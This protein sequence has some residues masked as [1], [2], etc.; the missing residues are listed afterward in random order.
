[1]YFQTNCQALKY[2]YFNILE[3]DTVLEY[4]QTTVYLYLYFRKDSA[5][6]QTMM[7]GRIAAQVSL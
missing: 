3:T 4:M 7:R 1:M 6:S 2:C 5:G